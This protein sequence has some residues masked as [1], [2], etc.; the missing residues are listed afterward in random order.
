M[1]K[2]IY[3]AVIL[4]GA[5]AA[6]TPAFAVDIGSSTTVGGQ[7]FFDFSH[8]TQEQNGADV[9]PTGTGFDVKRFYLTVDHTFDDTYSANL[10]T[11]AQFSSSTTAGSGGVTEV[12]IKKLYLQAK[13]D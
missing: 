6:T 9:V 12:F 7:A 1:R 13:Y 4:V 5:A 2:Q 3:A 11:D 10:T 8:I